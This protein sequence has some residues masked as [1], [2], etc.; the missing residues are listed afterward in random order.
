MW[1]TVNTEKDNAVDMKMGLPATTL[2]RMGAKEVEDD[3][4]YQI[5]VGG[6]S[7][8][9]EVNFLRYAMRMRKIEHHY[10]EQ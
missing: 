7:Q 4:V 1:G 8:A 6:T 5:L 3:F 9:P 2:R 10:S